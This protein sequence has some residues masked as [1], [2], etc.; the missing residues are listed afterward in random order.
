[1]DATI[2]DELRDRDP[3][4]LAA[5]GVEAAQ[6][7]R[8]RRVIDDQV[9]AGGLLEGADVATLPTDDPALH[10]VGRQ[11]DDADG[12]LRRVVRGDALHRGEDD[13]AGLVLGLLA[14]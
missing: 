8:L 2:G 14:G 10:L 9:D 12:V 1:V 5:H 3:G 4:D 11:M 6:D 7:D 13:V